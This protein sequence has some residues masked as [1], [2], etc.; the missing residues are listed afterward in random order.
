MPRLTDDRTIT[1]SHRLLPKADLISKRDPL[2]KHMDTI[3]SI[4]QS[5]MTL[6]NNIIVGENQQGEI[7][8]TM[9]KETSL[10]Q[11]NCANLLEQ[12][13]HEIT[14]AALSLDTQVDNMKTQPITL[15]FKS[16]AID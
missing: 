8:E 14:R 15:T 10:Y 2:K 16:K 9:L 6:A 12:I 7:A 13:R 4:D 3:E 11:T 1:I 5:L